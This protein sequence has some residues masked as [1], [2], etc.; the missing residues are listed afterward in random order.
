[1]RV[2]WLCSYA[3]YPPDFGGARRTYN[4]LVQAADAGHEVDLLAFAT[5]DQALDGAAMD[6]LGRLC[7]M[8]DLVADPAALPAALGGEDAAAVVRK[9]RGQLRSLASSRP[10]Q[11]FAHCSARMQA[12]VNRHA[13]ATAY[14]LVH[15]E[16]SQMG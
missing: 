4:L 9:R 3:P 13:A 6:A 7:R 8:V 12:A 16:A 2:L 11:Y 14:D 1:M 10:Y 15:V 5:G